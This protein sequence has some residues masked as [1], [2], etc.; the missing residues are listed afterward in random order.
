MANTIA[1][2]TWLTFLLQD[3]R[4]SLAS[5]LLLYCDNLSALH[6]TI[7][8]VFHARSKHI[9]LDYHYVREWVALGNLVTHHIPTNDQVA[10]L[11]TKPVSKATLMHFQA[12]LY[13]Q[14]QPRLREDINNNQLL[15]DNHAEKG[16]K[17][18]LEIDP[19]DCAT[20]NE[21]HEEKGNKEP[22]ETYPY[23]CATDNGKLLED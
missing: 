19:Y 2:L 20:N 6:M 23:D 21:N 18:P 14:P 4:I 16:N 3:L 13:L 15:D 17:E 10:D 7:N 1:E 9:E 22:L 8:L 12:K 5:L 11:F